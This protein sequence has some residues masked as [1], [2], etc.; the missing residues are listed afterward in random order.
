MMVY[1]CLFLESFFMFVVVGS[2]LGL[3][4]FLVIG[5]MVFIFYKYILGFLDFF[6]KYLII[7]FRYVWGM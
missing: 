2:V 1:Y 4:L 5:V 3:L 6:I 7:Y